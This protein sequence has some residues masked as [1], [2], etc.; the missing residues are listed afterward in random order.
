MNPAEATVVVGDVNHDVVVRPTGPFAADS[1]TPAAVTRA[2]G[3]S[4]ANQAVWLASLGVPVRLVSRVAAAER[5]DL[6]AGLADRGV[7]AHLGS[8]PARP[9]GCV[10]VIVGG[11][12]RAMYTDRGANESLGP[13]ELRPGVLE[14]AGHLHVSAYTLASPAAREP[15]AR[16]CAEASARGLPVTLDPASSSVLAAWPGGPLDLLAPVLG[17]GPV[18]ILLPNLDEATA[19]SGLAD[20]VA[21][22]E[23]LL[24]V[25]ST[26]VVKLGGGGV[27]AADRSGGRVALPA[28]AVAA[29]VDPTGAGDA[30]AAGYLAGWRLGR[31]LGACASAGLEAA[32]LAVG[33][34]G[35]RPPAGPTPAPAREAGLSR[36]EGPAP[37]R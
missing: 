29:V 19:L 27:V 6:A 16:L 21:A 5:A 30:F 24:A 32:G 2:P 15:M 26:V 13:D 23:A 7:E 1:D 28:A 12:A 8:D 14:G 20:P 37:A 3:G 35:A 25:A 33:T 18:E 10:V 31:P 11:S 9:T 36:A 22:A 34:V 4:A 17:A